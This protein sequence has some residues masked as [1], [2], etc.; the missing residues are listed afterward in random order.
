M[1][2]FKSLLSI[3]GAAPPRPP[4]HVFA[5]PSAPFPQKSSYTSEWCTYTM[6]AVSIH[7]C[8]LGKVFYNF[9][10]LQLEITCAPVCI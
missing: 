10:G 7:D 9:P 3:W 6:S 2:N 1:F 5:F 8:E 4:A